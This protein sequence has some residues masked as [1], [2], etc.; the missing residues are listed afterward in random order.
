MEVLLFMFADILLSHL[1]R[2][3][4]MQLEDCVKLAYQ[5]VFGP[6]HLLKD[7]Q[8][9]LKFLKDEMASCASNDDPLYLPIGNGLCRLSLPACKARGITAE[10][11]FPL[12]AHAAKT[13]KGDMRDLKSVI[14]EI[15]D[16]I[17]QDALPY[18]PGMA[19]YFFI[20]YEDKR[21]PLMHHSDAYKRA[22]APAYRVVWQKQLK[23]FLKTL[24]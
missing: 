17:D 18:D 13:V 5:N 8:K 11:I 22:Y 15:R 23:D 2:Y 1:E 21:Y 7:E 24:R 14:R 6:G 12:F 3:P 19:D 16:L 9:A 10:Q 4:D 20:R